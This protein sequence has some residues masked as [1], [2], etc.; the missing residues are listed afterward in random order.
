MPIPIF[1]ILAVVVPKCNEAAPAR[2]RERRSALPRNHPTTLHPK[3]PTQSNEQ[4]CR[5]VRH[6]GG[7]CRLKA[8]FLSTTAQA[9]GESFDGE[10][11]N[12]RTVR[13]VK[14]GWTPSVAHGCDTPNREET[15]ASMGSRSASGSARPG[16]GLGGP[17]DAPGDPWD[18]PGGPWGGPG[19][20][21]GGPL[22]D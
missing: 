11:V 10:W 21:L 6:N 3:P 4:D 9:G 12:G 18:G 20:P 19:G 16:S 7:H 5:F 1:L 22:L 8:T 14:R 13:V 15:D 17:S 2:K